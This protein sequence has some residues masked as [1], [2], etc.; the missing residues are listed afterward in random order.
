MAAEPHLVS[1][2]VAESSER[3]DAYY[4]RLL[5]T[6][7]GFL[8]FGVGAFAMGAIALPVV[9]IFPGSRMR[10][11]ARA[12]S[13]ISAG[14]KFFVRF[15]KAMG[16]W[17]YEFR[18]LERLGRP[19]QLVLANHP[20]LVDAVFLLS[21]M[22]TA[23]CIMK[24][25]LWR[26][27]LTRLAVTLCEYITNESASTMIEGAARA[28]R[29]GETLVMFPEGTRTKPHQPCVFHRGAANI[30]LRAARV[31]T[32]VYIRCQPTTLTKGEPWYHIPSRRIRMTLIVGEDLDLEPHRAGASVPLASRAFNEYLQTHFDAEL[33]RRSTERG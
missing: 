1:S 4:W 24:A 19:G 27:P 7:L 29:E 13:V 28:L 14:M 18:G 17:T 33:A 21:V 31:V 15:F 9:R 16:I 6:A 25:A 2:D 32:P 23:N 10:K 22:P 30:A 8:L 12:R 11:R 26:N 3:Q 20:S 5:G